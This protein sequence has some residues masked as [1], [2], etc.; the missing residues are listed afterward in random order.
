M[1]IEIYEPLIEHVDTAKMDVEINEATGTK[2]LY[3][4]G[5]TLV[6]DQKNANGRIYKKPILENAIKSHVGV[7]N[8]NLSVGGCVGELNHPL[9]GRSQTDPDR[10]AIKFVDVQDNGQYF[11]TKALVAEGTTCGKQIAGLFD[12]GIRLGI[13]SRGFGSTK[14][15]NGVMEVERLILESLGDVVFNPSAPGAYLEAIRESAGC[16]Y[17]MKAG[18]LFLKDS[19]KIEQLI[20]SH[21]D[22]INKATRSQIN[23]AAVAIFSDFINKCM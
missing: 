10:I 1:E 20:E 23:N 12:A 6:Y 3:I 5:P 21:N 22:I 18:N 15:S 2:S 19:S 17:I 7:N 9:G 4:H 13:S 11:T 8:E 16:E 14:K